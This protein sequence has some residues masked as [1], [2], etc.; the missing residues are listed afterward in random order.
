MKTV[1]PKLVVLAKEKGFEQKDSTISREDLVDWLRETHQIHVSINPW[2]YQSNGKSTEFYETN[3][4]DVKDNWYT[5]A[6]GSFYEDYYKAMQELL[7]SALN[8]IP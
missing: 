1:E 2:E 7:T 8:L 3:I 4:V 5:F 6:V